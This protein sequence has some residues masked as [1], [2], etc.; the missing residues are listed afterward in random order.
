M[1]GKTFNTRCMFK[2]KETTIIFI[3]ITASVDSQTTH[4]EVFMQPHVMASAINQLAS[5]Q[6]CL[7]GKLSEARSHS[8]LSPRHVVIQWY[9]NTKTKV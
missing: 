7:F 3:S 2:Y 9:I 5:A 8:M 6:S 1:A 4:Q